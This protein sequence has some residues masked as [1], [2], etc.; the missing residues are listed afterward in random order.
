[1]ELV[2]KLQQATGPR[3]LQKNN[4]KQH[5]TYVSMCMCVHTNS[6]DCLLYMFN[7]MVLINY[8][9]IIKIS[10]DSQPNPCTLI[11]NEAYY[12]INLLLQK[13]RDWVYEKVHNIFLIPF[14]PY[15]IYHEIIERL[16]RG[17]VSEGEGWIT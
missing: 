4:N 9:I 1:M 17:R 8:R 11:Q 15:S 12:L 14:N 3:N 2:Y 7:L 13:R 16:D 6:N 10:N 5:S